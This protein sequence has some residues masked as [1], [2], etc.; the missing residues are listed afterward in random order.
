MVVWKADA[1]AVAIEEEAVKG[2]V[3]TVR[4]NPE[5]AGLGCQ[6]ARSVAHGR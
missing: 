2:S 3:A 4:A 6:A 5:A 1:R